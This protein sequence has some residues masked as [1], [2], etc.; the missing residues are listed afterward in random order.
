MALLFGFGLFHSLFYCG[1][2]LIIFAVLGLIP[3][4]LWRLPSR[5]LF[6]I[7]IFLLISPLALYN[8]LMGQSGVLFE[9]Y[10]QWCRLHELPSAPSAMSSTWLQMAEWNITVG[11]QH[12]WLY[13]IWSN[14][15]GLVIGMFLLGAALGKSGALEAKPVTYA[16]WSCLFGAIYLL[17]MLLN[18]TSLRLDWTDTMPLWV[19]V[20][21]VLTFASLSAWLL[22]LPA[23]Q[24]R[25]SQLCSMGRMSLSCYITQSIIMT[26]LLASWG[27]GMLSKLNKTELALCALTLYLVQLIFCSLWL[28]Y[29][30]FGPIEGLWRYLTQLRSPCKISSDSKNNSK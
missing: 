4:A 27:M 12:A 28:R 23:I 1:D 13:M 29:F 3:W 19:N 7:S 25:I 14:R 20:S 21:F 9:W 26:S 8:D 16:K 18:Q 17:L 5:F 2:I 10:V 24:S 30:K 11:T 22:R 6:I 15:L